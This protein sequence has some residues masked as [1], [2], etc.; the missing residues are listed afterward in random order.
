[1]QEETLKKANEIKKRIEQLDK[2]IERLFD[3][4]PPTRDAIKEKRPDRFGWILEIGRRKKKSNPREETIMKM[5]YREIEITND[6]IRAMMNLRLNELK[7]LRQEM[8]EL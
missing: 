1:M 4:M 8:E 2:E 7:E 5:G 6:D 3:F